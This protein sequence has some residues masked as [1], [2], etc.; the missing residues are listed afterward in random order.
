[1]SRR[2]ITLT[3]VDHGDVTLPEPSWC[4]GHDDH[5]PDSHR[6]DILHRGPEVELLFRGAEVLT[7][8]LA[9]SPYATSTDPG[10]GGRTVGVSVYPPGRTLAPVG[11]YELAAALDSYADQVRG[12]AEQLTAVLAGGEDQ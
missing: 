1:M 3:T 6:S 9:H 4:V 5:Q 7:A 8:C 2:T 12:L 10:L 11:L